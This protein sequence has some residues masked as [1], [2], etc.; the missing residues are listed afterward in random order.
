VTRERDQDADRHER[1][2]ADFA[3]SDGA[4][5]LTRQ[6][7]DALPIPVSWADA[8][9][10]ISYW[11]RRAEALFGYSSDEV[12]DLETWYERAFPDAGYRRDFIER[13]N[14]TL[15][16]A[17]ETSQESHFEAVRVRTR[18]GRSVDV[19]LSGTFVGER[20]LLV[21]HDVTARLSAER[22]VRYSEARLSAAFSA[23]PDACAVSNVETG[24]YV[25]VNEGFARI[26][27][28]S[29]DEAVGKNSAD[30]DLW[31]D[32]AQRAEVLRQLVET[33]K[34]DHFEASFR[35]KSGKTILTLV[36]GRVIS[37]DGTPFIVTITRDVTA[38]RALEE[39]LRVS[40]RLDSIGRLAG[41]V[42]HDFNNLL[43]VIQGNLDLALAELP[44]EHALRPALE[45]TYD[46]SVRAATITRQLL[47][48]GR[49]QLLTARAVSL[50]EVI[51]NMAGLLRRVVGEAI[52]VTFELASGLSPV[53]VDRAQLEQVILNLVLNARDAM[54]R[55]GKLL[56]ETE[57]VPA[58]TV[59]EA[60]TPAR[61][62]V[63]LIVED[64][65]TGMT[66]EV[67]AR[68]FE[69][70]FTTKGR[71][72]GMGLGLASVY[73]IVQQSGGKIE[74]SSELGGGSSFVVHFPAASDDVNPSR[75]PQPVVPRRGGPKTVLVAEDQEAVR[76][77][78]SRVLEQ[79]GLSVLVAA[80]AE[81][82]EAVA[83]G[84][85]G[86]IDL[87]LTDVV[88]PRTSGS[89]LAKRLLLANPGLEVVY[90]SGF[91]ADTLE[92]HEVL[93][94]EARLL[95]KPFTPEALRASVA[96]ALGHAAR[97]GQS[98]QTEAEAPARP[99]SSR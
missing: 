83:R 60:G 56:L 63:R 41:G 82:A 92:Q 45:D 4:E 29:I 24:R 90:M 59:G 50:N 97:G 23:I 46:A 16:R 55:G 40:E 88:M 57:P 52:E 95:H 61:G 53:L 93:G 84:H 31:V 80:N 35:H 11:N 51:E 62:A 70:F 47:A 98:G 33:G 27:G 74:V 34:I 69:P 5:S 1:P 79:D 6:M 77:L 73:G 72:Q 75:R 21:F 36:S 39:K 99:P 43:T 17:R 64:T 7:L 44:S 22:A 78:V 86:G 71:T 76:R 18:S 10:R 96:E 58:L 19:E 38:E 89:E 15:L 28:W 20:L 68:I 65:G 48:F 13:W 32:R 87:L 14:S 91:A 30:L 54:P 8:D 66:P 67:R 37:A 42:A 25:L 26:T 3:E 49:R 85:H 2:P 81:E 94:A 9:G 12:P